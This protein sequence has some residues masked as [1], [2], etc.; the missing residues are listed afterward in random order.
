MTEDDSNTGLDAEKARL[1]GSIYEVVLHPEHFDAFMED[2]SGYIEQAARRLGELHVTQGPAASLLDDPGIEVHFQRAFALFERMGRGESDGVLADQDHAPLARLGRGGTVSYATTQA[3]A[4]FGHAPSLAKICDAL[5]D[6]SARRLQIFLKTFERAPASGRFAVLSL[7]EDNS[8]GAEGLTGGGLVAVVTCRNPD[9]DGFI[10]E[11]RP[12]AIGWSPALAAILSESFQLTPREVDLVRELTSGGDLP[13]I[14]ARTGRSQNTIRAQLKSVF[15][16]TRTGAQTELLRLIAV[17]VLHGPIAE[18]RV[19]PGLDSGHEVR[20]ELGDG[21]FMAVH[22]LGPDD[23]LPVVFVHGMLDGLGIL[24]HIGPNLHA[25][26]VRLIAP[27]R[28]NFG[29]SQHSQRIKE[30]PDLFARDLG[31]VLEKLGISRCIIAGHMAGG[32]YAYA[33]AARLKNAIA[34]IA[35]ISGCVPIKSIEQ[36][37]SMTTRQRAVA[38]TARFAPAFLPAVLRAGIARIDSRDVKRFMT[39]L[40]PTGCRDR[41]II[42]NPAIA[43]SL[44]DGYRFTVAQGPVAFQIDAWHVTRDWS[45]LVLASECPVHL[46]HGRLDPVVSIDSVRAFAQTSA[47]IQLHEIETEGQLL[48]YGRP[49]LAISE[50]AAFARSCLG[51]AE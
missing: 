9:G 12:L 45:A 24:Q 20:V 1:I 48:F 29:Q 36:F 49:D 11:L 28:D 19:D 13:T 4:L 3:T 41:T 43:A 51:V 42:E 34:G 46:I 40:Y 38:Y 7:A 31:M 39:P 22:T 27:V 32:V 35:N 47:R 16:K 33:A 37:A 5:T 30:A 14:A 26:G 50:L 6:D 21:R 2:W 44:I 25:A 10:A 18:R 23:G 8:P 17:L 15:A